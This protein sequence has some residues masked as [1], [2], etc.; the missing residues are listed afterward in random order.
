MSPN[1]FRHRPYTR[2][3]TAEPASPSLSQQDGKI[4]QKPQSTVTPTGAAPSQTQQP[5]RVQATS[6]SRKLKSSANEPL[7]K[8]SHDLAAGPGPHPPQSNPQQPSESSQVHQPQRSYHAQQPHP[9]HPQPARLETPRGHAE[10][11]SQQHTRIAAVLG[12]PIPPLRRKYS[13][14]VAAAVQ[15]SS[16]AFATHA[17]SLTRVLALQPGMLLQLLSGQPL[18]LLIPI[19][20][21][22]DRVA[23]LQELLGA[24]SAEVGQL[25]VAD[26]DVLA[27]KR[28][29]RSALDAILKVAEAATHG[30]ALGQQQQQQQ[31]RNPPADDRQA[32]SA[33]SSADARDSHHTSSGQGG[34]GS[35]AGGE[36]GGGD[37]PV[38]AS[39]AP[40]GTEALLKSLLRAVRQRPGLLLAQEA[41]VT[42]VVQ[43][44]SLQLG[45]TPLAA[46]QFAVRQPSLLCSPRARLASNI[47]CLV[48]TF[49]LDPPALLQLIEAMPQLLVMR[50]SPAWSVQLPKLVSS[51]HNL[52]VALSFDSSRFHR[53]QYLVMTGRDRGIGYKS[54]LS[55]LAADFSEMYPGYELWRHE[56]GR[57]PPPLAARV[58]Q[59]H[60]Q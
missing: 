3:R 35:G 19:H 25:M 49:K 43:E 31:Q 4:A 45:L 16:E 59:Q 42:A 50:Y 6:Q 12:C 20:T 48:S 27:S 18:I 32:Q 51:P 2:Y 54:A 17:A 23:Q 39:P 8:Y 44:L 11:E 40:P 36:D 34:T 53:L 41:Q 30:R 29:Y 57:G 37:G 14:I 22:E 28:P 47:N 7:P 33:V 58:Q 56:W 60:M 46:A 15:L 10:M 5:P 9:S 52:A 38:V 26:P 1:L 21:I 13:P 24:S 55:M